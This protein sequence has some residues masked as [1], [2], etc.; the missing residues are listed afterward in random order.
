V[1]ETKHPDNFLSFYISLVFL[2][3]NPGLDYTIYMKDFSCVLFWE[4]KHGVLKEAP[5]KAVF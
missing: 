1:R 2:S 5:G 4:G 3:K